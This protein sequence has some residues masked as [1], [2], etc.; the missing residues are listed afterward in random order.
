MPSRKLNLPR[1]VTELLEG[2]GALG[3]VLFAPVGFGLLGVKTILSQGFKFSR[4]WTLLWAGLLIPLPFQILAGRSPVWLLGQVALALLASYLLTVGRR[5]LLAGLTLGLLCTAA[6]GLFERQSFKNLWYSETS[7]PP[8]GDLL[9]GVSVL[10][11]DSSGWRR[12]GL[13]R[14]EKV[15]DLP[16]QVEE[17]ELSFQ[18]KYVE[19]TADWD[20]YTNDPETEVELHEA[21]LQSEGEPFTRV[22]N[23][24]RYIVRRVNTGSPVGGRTFRASLELRTPTNVTAANCKGLQLRTF[25]EIH[26]VCEGLE[27]DATWRRYTLETTFPPDAKLPAFELTVQ[28]PGTTYL[29]VR[30]VLVQE[31][32]GGTWLDLPPPEP[33]G[34]L[35]R[36]D[37]PERHIFAH[38]R[39]QFIPQKEWQTY[40]LTVAPPLLEGLERVSFI[41][42]VEGGLS[43]ALRD[44]RLVSLTPDTPNPRALA[45]TR[46]RYWFSHANLAGHTVVS[47]SIVLLT[48]VRSGWLGGVLFLLALLSTYL[49]GSRA[50]L[51][52]L[53]LGSLGIGWLGLRRKGRWFLAGLAVAG[54]FVLAYT[55]TLT[56]LWSWRDFSVNPVGRLEIWRVG[57][58]TALQHPL[59]GIGAD[60]FGQAW[61]QA[62]QAIPVSHAHNLWLDFA[63]SYGVPGLL[64][65]LWLTAGFLALAWRWGRWRGLALVVPIFVMNVFD[66]TFFYS[67]VLFPLILGLNALRQ[68]RLGT[69]AAS[70]ASYTKTS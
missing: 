17:V 46:F 52:A 68:G 69:Q 49:S 53:G 51:L 32:V 1:Y 12:N 33:A 38:P 26:S 48:F 66:Y 64:A 41:L 40:S 58:Q 2:V 37:L 65:S 16:A 60:N 21:E 35:V 42:Q 11:G 34:V 15:W 24:Q 70:A 9:R 7:P 10:D 4:A 54:L 3:L 29:D 18:T 36:L 23:P 27:L 8:V 31:H 43:V 6:F 28:D 20:W 57:Y 62:G 50:A 39:L 63:A 25:Q 44:V 56:P 59:F 19:G 45:L 61:A 22:L 13:S 47:V 67:G 30:N 5:A 55:G 14:V